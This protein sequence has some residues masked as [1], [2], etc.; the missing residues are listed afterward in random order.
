MDR[1]EITVTTTGI[2]REI[3]PAGWPVATR[4]EPPNHQ[5]QPLI[6]FIQTHLS[7]FLS[8]S[9]DFFLFFISPKEGCQEKK[10]KKLLKKGKAPSRD[11]LN[12][13]RHGLGGTCRSNGIS[14]FSIIQS[15]RVSP[16]VSSSPSSSSISH[17]MCD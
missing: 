7:L 1:D 8:F 5:I 12:A 11:T 6:G 15:P 13:S 16:F 10:K 9:F 3:G 4:S 2:F 14:L 17:S